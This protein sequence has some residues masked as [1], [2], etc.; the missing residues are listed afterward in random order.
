MARS[1]LSRGWSRRLMAVSGVI[2][3]L[4]LGGCASS[5][6]SEPDTVPESQLEFVPRAESAPAL[7]TMDTSFWA[8]KGQNRRLEIRYVGFGGDDSGERFLRLEIEEQTL[9]RRPDGTPFADG[10]SIEIRVVVDP[11]LFLGNFEPSGL[12]F[13]PNEP[14]ELEYR[15][16][17]ADADFLVREAEFDLWRQERSGDP[18]ERLGSLQ[19]EDL[20]EI[21]VELFGF[22]RY[23]LAVGR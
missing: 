23:A 19:V 16:A 18:W 15:Y 21:E 13:N 9:L 6:D 4:A 22:T 20:D 3:G 2:L 8:V 7:E 1:R 11:V 5:N 14:A 10:D 12:Q 17:E